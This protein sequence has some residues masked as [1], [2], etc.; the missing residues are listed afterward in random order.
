MG[1]WKEKK[2]GYRAAV[3]LCSAVITLSAII[4]PRMAEA[5]EDT[6]IKV[7]KYYGCIE[8][9]GKRV[10][11][12]EHPYEIARYDEAGNETQRTKYNKSG[13]VTEKQTYAYNKAGC[14]T[15]Y[16]GYK[17]REGKMEKIKEEKNRYDKNNRLLE[18]KEWHTSGTMY[19]N[20][21]ATYVYDKKGLLIEKNRYTWSESEQKEEHCW[22]QKYEYDERGNLIEK[23]R[24]Y[25]WEEG[26]YRWKEVY[27]YTENNQILTYTEQGF[28]GDIWKSEEYAYNEDGKLIEYIKKDG[29]Y[30]SDVKRESWKYDENGVLKE[31]ENFY[32]KDFLDKS[33]YEEDGKELECIHYF[34][35]K[36]LWRTVFI[37]DTKDNLIGEYN[38]DKNGKKTRW[39]E[40]KYDEKGRLIYW[41]D[42]TKRSYTYSYNKDGKLRMIQEKRNGKP[43]YMEKYAYYN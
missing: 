2:Y 38:Y 40:N 18:T 9:K 36:F 16:C 17:N 10:L 32:D 35:G 7:K 24:Y 27:T 42:E 12:T 5:K 25:P 19:Y 30:L 6:G 33:F 43:E 13:K 15:E 11:D 41:E 23:G 29:P 28:K 37:Y 31:S 39:G 21:R 3:L 34:K 14:L 26:K 20:Y 22:T 8:V 1:I 4:S